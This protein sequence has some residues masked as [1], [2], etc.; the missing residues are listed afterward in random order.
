MRKR[1]SSI[2]KC[3]HSWRIMFEEHNKLTKASYWLLAIS[4]LVGFAFLYVILTQLQWDQPWVTYVVSAVLSL[5]LIFNT[6]FAYRIY[7]RSV[8]ALKFCMW[9]Y[10]L[11]I[12][13]FETENWAFSFNFG[14]NISVS[15]AYEST[16]VTINL[17]AILI[18]IVIFL[19]YRSINSAN[20]VNQ[21]GTS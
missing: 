15:W 14:M 5:M 17:L 6:Y 8:R 13:G 3:E 1:V 19:A 10:G 4:S 11:Q 21:S 18:F 2:Y 20:K 12:I 9:L 16:E 7:K